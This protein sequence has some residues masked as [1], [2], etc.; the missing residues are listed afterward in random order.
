MPSDKPLETEKEML[1]SHID[2]GVING[3][4]GQAIHE[5][6]DTFNLENVVVQNTTDD[7]ITVT[8]DLIGKIF[9]TVMTTLPEH[10]TILTQ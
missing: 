4:S 9:A 7:L 1:D 10:L 2:E 5:L 8:C 3:D 6:V